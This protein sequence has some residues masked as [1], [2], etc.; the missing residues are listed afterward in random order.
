[1][2]S[3]GEQTWQRVSARSH[4]DSGQRFSGHA[5]GIEYAIIC[6]TAQGQPIQSEE[7]QRPL[8]LEFVGN[9]HAHEE[10]PTLRFVHGIKDE[11]GRV[12]RCACE[13]HGIYRKRRSYSRLLLLFRELPKH[14][15]NTLFNLFPEIWIRN[16]RRK[17]P[18]EGL[19]LP[20]FIIG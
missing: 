11:K 18:V 7:V 1:R 19:L 12:L 8:V 3:R 13:G 5:V 14:E 9:D 20:E 6:L 15:F 17:L 2:D 16:Y 10:N 4:C